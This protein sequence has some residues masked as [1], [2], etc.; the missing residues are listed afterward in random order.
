M[1]F[2]KKTFIIIF[3]IVF[4]P[5]NLIA[6]TPYFLDFKFILNESIAGKQAQ[7]FLKNKL[8]KG[9]K[10]IQDKQKKLQEEENKLIQKKK[11]I[12]AEEY[13]KNVTALRSKV[14]ALQKERNNLLENVSKQRTKARKE[15]LSKLNPIIKNYMKE[16]NIRMVVD[17]KS[18]LLADENLNI[19]K[20]ILDRLNKKIKSIEIK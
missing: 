4:S 17:K 3:F 19:T 13:K 20:E 2:F 14:S 18:L 16:K 5:K 10:S 6:E 15:L 12:S 7:V 1:K 8:E 9:A 11:I